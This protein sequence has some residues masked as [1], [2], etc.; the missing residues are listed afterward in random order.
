MFDE[1]DQESIWRCNEIEN[2]YLAGSA[3]C[4]VENMTRRFRAA[5]PG[6]TTASLFQRLCRIREGKVDRSVILASLL[7]LCSGAAHA[8]TLRLIEAPLDLPLGVPNSFNLHVADQVTN[9]DN[10]F[11]VP[12]NFSL[13][14]LLGD[15]DSRGDVINLVSAGFDGHWIR[16]RQVVLYSADAGKEFFN[17][18]PTL[19]N[20]TATADVTWN[21]AASSIINGDLGVDYAKLL[22]GF[23]N[24]RRFDKDVI[25]R[26]TIFADGKWDVGPIFSL[27]GGARRL[28][29]DNSSPDR[30]VDSISLTTANIGGQF[31]FAATNSVGVEYQ[32]SNGTYVNRVFVPGLLNSDPDF[33]DDSGLILLKYAPGTQ[34]TLDARAG[35]LKRQY[36]N[37][38][39]GDFSGNVWSATLNWQPSVKTRVVA[40]AYRDL[41]AYLEAQSNYFVAVG[42]GITPTW[43]PTEKITVGLQLT[44]EHQAYISSSAN[45]VTSFAERRDE[46]VAQQ[47]QITYVPITA[48]T[49]NLAYRNEKRSSNQADFSYDDRVATAK[50]VFKF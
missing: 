44:W 2:V 20:T 17:R 18:H 28:K 29:V 39:D 4:R 12:K 40:T 15:K 19:N 22:G 13:E 41:H 25:N 23:T 33:H 31:A 34:L 48:L 10:L 30:K 26:T 49:I 36:E 32:R 6:L 50:A 8:Q 42:E 45:Q 27:F 16:G 47:L 3:C 7:A 5:Y 37:D 43:I 11:R 21:W 46:V 9:D 35:Y 14:P 1:D 38:P 24:T